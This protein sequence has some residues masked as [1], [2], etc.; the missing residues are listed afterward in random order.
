MNGLSVRIGGSIRA[1]SQDDWNQLVTSADGEGDCDNPFVDWRFLAALEDGGCAVA[2]RGFLPCPFVVYADG[3]PVAAAPAYVKQDSDGDFSRD[4]DWAAA[5]ERAGLSYYPKLIFGIPFTPVT[6]RR[7][8]FRADLLAAQRDAIYAALLAAARRFCQEQRI[9][10]LHVLFPTATQARDLARHGLASRVAFQYHWN[11]PGYRDPEE[12]YARFSSKRR[13]ALKRER[14]A[15]QSQGIALRTVRGDEIARDPQTY[16]DL[17]HALHSS[18]VDKLIWGRRWLT[19]GFYRQ[20]FSSL[21]AAVELVLAERAGQVVAGAFNVASDDGTPYGERDA[22]ALPVR[23]LYGRYWGCFEDHPFLHFN[24]CYYH[25]ID[26]CIRR[27][28]RI[29]EGGAGG[30]H[31]IARGFEPS[32]TYSAHAFFDPRLDV[33]LRRHLQQETQAR[34]QAI[35]EYREKAP[36]LKPWSA[37]ESPDE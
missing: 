4:W 20:L 19:Q 31:K 21:P 33:A 28:V 22:S 36:V 10:S 1:L 5:A 3:Q 25:S 16:A 9:A 12:F 37:S 26:E 14:S 7:V 17:A 8:L 15:A 27:K 6:G 23:R 35:A 18:T 32:E 29:F 30:E 24:V 34:T 11:N 2:A 13:N